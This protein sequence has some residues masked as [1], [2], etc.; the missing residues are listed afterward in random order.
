MPPYL[1]NQSPTFIFMVHPRDLFDLQQVGGS[2]VIAAYS[3]NEEEFQERM[4]MLPPTIVGDF[5]FGIGKRRGELLAVLCMPD[6]IMHVHGRRQI[7]EGLRVAADRGATVVGLGELTA[8]ATR[9]GV[10]LLPDLPAGI[11][12]TTGNA[13]TAAIARQ[14]VVEASMELGLGGRATVAI[15]GCTG[16]VGVAASRLLAAAGFELL[17]IGRNLDRVH[18]ELPDLSRHFA[19]SGERTDVGKADIVLLLTGDRSA[20]LTPTDP[21]PESIVIDFAQPVNIQPSRYP[22]FLEHGVRVTEGGLVCIPGY[23]SSLDMRTADP[24]ATFACLAETYLFACEGIREHA[25]GQASVELALELERVAARHRVRA[26][27]LDLTIPVITEQSQR[28]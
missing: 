27:P 6:R 18:R 5:T 3:S 10:A 25:V 7:L 11:T 9:G 16:S 4:L 12:L 19:V 20:Q 14:N 17:L 1:S 21:R 8:P 23:R 28:R 13:Y 24:K 15:V 26:R 2:S 22:A